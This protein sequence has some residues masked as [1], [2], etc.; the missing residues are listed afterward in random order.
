MLSRWPIRHKLQLGVAILF[1]IVAMLAFSGF[2]GVYAYRELARSIS[3]RAAEL[4]KS[5]ILLQHVES[6]RFG[7][8][9]AAATRR[10]THGMEFDGFVREEFRHNLQ[11]VKDSLRDYREVLDD[12]DGHENRINDIRAE[13]ETVQRIEE[14]LARIM[15]LDRADDWILHQRTQIASL[16]PELEILHQLTSELP[17]FLHQRMSTLQGDVRMRYRTWIVMT[18]FSSL[19]AAV[20]LVVLV[21]YFHTWVFRP[22]R[23]LIEASRRVAEDNFDSQISVSSHD[24]IGELAGAM[25]AMTARFR[26]IRDD[27]NQEVKLRTK[28]VVRSEQL[29]SVGFLAAGVA[30]EINNP[31]ASIAWSAEALESRIEELVGDDLEGEESEYTGIAEI[32]GDMSSEGR[33]ELQELEVL[34]KYLRRIQDEAFRCKGIT[35][36]LLDFSRMG[37][38]EREETDLRELVESVVEIVQHLGKYRDKELVVTSN[39]MVMAK[40]NPQEMKQVILNLLTN[41][42]DCIDRGGRVEVQL[43]KREGRAE[44]LVKDN[45]CGMTEEVKEHLFEPFFTRRRDGSGTGLGL[46]ITY[47]IIQDHGGS[48]TAESDG[49]GCGSLF[50]VVLPLVSHEKKLER[51]Y[52]AA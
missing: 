12:S 22:L 18:W 26:E 45:G 49:P 33:R 16:E 34:R 17:S 7:I 19:S 6:L 35:E 25:N 41:A 51:R 27:L 21:V 31:L 20:L 5:A 43:G 23:T 52:Q 11:Q 1:L 46:S 36:R 28:E 38:V 3:E 2:R 50:R 37:N 39:E 40:A 24:E 44:L 15:T 30:H 42:L 29:A 48:I 8:S 9:Q 13:H 47:R 10:L 14:C 32:D 4:P